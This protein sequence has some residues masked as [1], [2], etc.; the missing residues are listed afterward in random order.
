MPLTRRSL[1]GQITPP[2]DAAALNALYGEICSQVT[3][4]KDNRPVVEGKLDM[5]D[6]P[7]IDLLESEL[8][9]LLARIPDSLKDVY[10]ALPERMQNIT[11]EVQGPKGS[12]APPISAT[13]GRLG[14][15]S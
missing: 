2:R 4:I 1:Q 13:T 7:H 8:G 6:M 15:S 9:N 10:A 14:W 3:R 11:S 5:R 12:A